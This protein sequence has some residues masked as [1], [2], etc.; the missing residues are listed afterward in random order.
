MKLLILCSKEYPVGINKGENPLP[1]GGIE[2]YT[3]NLVEVFM[4]GE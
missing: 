1:S 4:G 2:I 3:E